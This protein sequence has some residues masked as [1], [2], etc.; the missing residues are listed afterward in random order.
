MVVKFKE[1]ITKKIIFITIIA[2][3]FVFIFALSSFFLKPR[4]KT[5][6]LLEP[7]KI[8]SLSSQISSIT[9]GLGSIGQLAGFDLSSLGGDDRELSEVAQANLLSRDFFKEHLYEKFLPYLYAVDY[10]D[11]GTKLIVF[12]EDYYDAKTSIWVERTIPKF[13]SSFTGNVY[14]PKP[15]LEV[16]YKKFY[17]DYFSLD[18]D[19]KTRFV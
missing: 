13:I 3:V 4:F 14:D 9:G 8:E 18:E 6:I 1:K 19:V 16:A 11:K 2:T 15:S 17:R 10:Y 7:V 5:D 12:D